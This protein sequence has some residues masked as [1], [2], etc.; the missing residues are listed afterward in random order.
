MYNCVCFIL[1]IF[2]T[3]SCYH[4]SQDTNRN[5]LVF[6]VFPVDQSV[7]SQKLFQLDEEGVENI[8]L[9]GDSVMLVRDAADIKKYHFSFYN[10]H[11]RQLISQALVFGGKKGQSLGFL[12]NSYGISGRI[13]WV[14]DV[15]REQFLQTSIDS[16]LNQRP[17]T[18]T[19]SKMKYSIYSLAAL[20]TQ[21]A[22]VFDNEYESEYKLQMMDI[23]KQENIRPLTSYP[24][25]FTR[26]DRSAYEGFV[27]IN[28]AG[29]KTVL[30]ARYADRI[31]ICDLESGENKIVKG[32]ENYE[33]S[34]KK[35]KQ[36]DGREISIKDANTRF[37][38]SRGKTTDK[39]IYLLYSG[40]SHTSQHRAR[41]KSIY[42]YDW[43]GNPVKKIVLKNYVRDFAV[44]ADESKLY[45]YN[46]Q[47]RYIEIAQL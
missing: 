45:V 23:P 5:A 10:I 1:S 25:G 33:P 40:N 12:A 19:E 29:T 27:F 21:T 26:G 7:K 4:A 8:Y 15:V 43:E 16:I 28:P 14:H 9:L 31:E 6:R 34:L 44:S 2:I 30:A 38:F 32:P 35:T 18:F 20:N 39:H 47:T 3:N 42:V 24:P 46:P 13:L 17:H 41:G 36:L 22:V 11:K 37:A